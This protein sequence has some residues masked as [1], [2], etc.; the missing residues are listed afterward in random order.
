MDKREATLYIITLFSLIAVFYL[1]FVVISKTPNITGEKSMSPTG[2]AIV[3]LDDNFKVGDYFNENIPISL[4]KNNNSVYGLVLLTKGNSPVLTKTFDLK[5]V[6][7]TDNSGKNI[8]KISDLVNYQFN[9]SGNY[10]F[11]FSILDLNINIKQE[12]LVK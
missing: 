11:L 3:G 8:V 5:D 12:I 7:T 4:E 1:A 2:N 6:L 9:E 10:E